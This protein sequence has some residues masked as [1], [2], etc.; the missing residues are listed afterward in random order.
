VSAEDAPFHWRLDIVREPQG[1]RVVRALRVDGPAP[2]L[3]RALRGLAWR[4][5]VVDAAGALLFEGELAD[6]AA[7]RGEFHGAPGQPIEAVHTTHALPVTFSIRVPSLPA[8]RIEFVGADA[9]PLGSVS[10]PGAP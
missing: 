9:A 5:R 1:F 3:R 10:F 4:F 7:L 8:A 6:P 2:K